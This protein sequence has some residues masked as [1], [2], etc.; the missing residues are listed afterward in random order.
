MTTCTIAITRSVARVKAV[1]YLPIKL[2]L[3]KEPFLCKL[4]QILEIEESEKFSHSVH[5]DEPT[6][7]LLQVGRKRAYPSELSKHLP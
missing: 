7:P 1:F 3:L 4:C 6:K 5:P 2:K